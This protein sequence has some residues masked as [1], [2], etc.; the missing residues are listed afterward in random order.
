MESNR[1][2]IEV[3]ANILSSNDRQAD[4]NRAHFRKSNCLAIN[5]IGSPG[6]G[7]TTLL[8]KTLP[9]LMLNMQVGVIEGDIFTSKDADRIA[10]YKV[11]VIQ[12]NTGGG[13]HLDSKMVNK[14][15]PEFEGKGIDLL[16]IENVGNLVC[17][18]DFDLGEAFKVIVLSIVEGDDKP[19]KYPVIF[20]NAKVVVLNKMDLEALTDVNMDNMRQDI[21]A[22]NP[23]IRIFEVSCRNGNGL[24]EWTSWLKQEVG[25]YQNN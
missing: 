6:A 25:N 24:E 14:V 21:L 2:E 7:K 22:I 12:I 5:V 3:M 23:D 15:L 17:P 10:A 4:L 8:E 9:L 13:C 19:A 16:I 18:A 1:R 11:P 20:R